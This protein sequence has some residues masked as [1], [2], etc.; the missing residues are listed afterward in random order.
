MVYK[1]RQRLLPRKPCYSSSMAPLSD[2]SCTAQQLYNHRQQLEC[3]LA[4][5]SRAAFLDESLLHGRC[6]A[7]LNRAYKHDPN[8]FGVPLLVDSWANG[9]PLRARQ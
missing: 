9:L 7:N 8:G 1:A 6:A 2:P 3:R 5:T 4:R